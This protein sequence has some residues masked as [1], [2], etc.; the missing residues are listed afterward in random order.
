MQW[1]LVDIFCI[2]KTSPG[3]LEIR[4]LNYRVVSLSYLNTRSMLFTPCLPPVRAV[5]RV[6]SLQPSYL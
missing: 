4:V 5:N 3:K 2:M 1:E 6:I